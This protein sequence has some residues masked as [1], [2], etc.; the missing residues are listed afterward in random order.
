MIPS[1]ALLALAG[2]P[3]GGGPLAQLALAVAVLCWLVG[4]TAIWLAIHHGYTH[5]RQV[6]IARRMAV[7]TE[8]LLPGLA[9]PDGLRGHFDRAVERAGPRSVAAVLRQLRRQV[10]GEEAQTLSTL[11][12]TVGEVRRLERLSRSR[13]AWL[14]A[15]AA[16]ALGECGGER[17]EATLARLTTDRHYLVRRAARLTLVDSGRG[18]LA[19]IAVSSFLAEAPERRGAVFFARLAAHHAPRLRELLASGL[20][21]A[22]GIKNALEAFGYQRDPASASSALSFVDSADP[23]LRA[24]AVRVL[25]LV[26]PAEHWPQVLAGLADEVWF[27]RACAARALAGAG[28]APAIEEGLGRALRDQYWWVRANA[29]RALARRGEP[30]VRELLGAL[31]GPDRYARDAALSAL[32]TRDALELV[33][34]PLRALVAASPEDPHLVEL[35]AN[36]RLQH[37]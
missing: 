25:G 14:R 28:A 19:E 11:L 6:R 29:A 15:M 5:A 36:A 8:V 9:D 37:V 21:D 26:A 16:R 17:A 12:E 7:A 4:A 32:A 10:S 27:V 1:G 3:S 35:L 30:G 13:R 23:E 24:S 34:G 20:L 22:T 18:E 2:F 31:S 33:A